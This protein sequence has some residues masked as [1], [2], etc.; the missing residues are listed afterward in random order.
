[1]RTV[2]VARPRSPQRGAPG[3]CRLKAGLSTQRGLHRDVIP[4]RRPGVHLSLD[5]DTNDLGR[6]Q[7]SVLQFV[8][9]QLDAH[10]PRGVV[11][12]ELLGAS[13]DV[14]HDSLPK[15]VGDLLQREPKNAPPSS[16]PEL[17]SLLVVRTKGWIPQKADVLENSVLVRQA[18]TLQ[19]SSVPLCE[20]FRSDELLVEASDDL[21]RHGK[22]HV[23]GTNCGRAGCQYL[24]LEVLPLRL[25]GS[26][27]L[28][29]KLQTL[30]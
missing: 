8:P 12:I 1:L 22:A 17:A 14:V 18:S 13:H 9:R 10:P 3:S 5:E 2:S 27:Q 15:L 6:A 23:V 7:L 4:R 24:L 21:C 30:L 16:R 28:L 29:N 20:A 25:C 19:K 26:Y 11:L